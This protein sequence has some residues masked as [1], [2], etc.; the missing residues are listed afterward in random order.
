MVTLIMLSIAP[1]FRTIP[2]FTVRTHSQI[3]AVCALS[4]RFT[5]SS[6]NIKL[7]LA[8]LNTLNIDWSHV[9]RIQDLHSGTSKCWHVSSCLSVNACN[10]SA[11]TLLPLMM[12]RSA[13]GNDWWENRTLTSNKNIATLIGTRWRNPAY[14]WCYA[15]L[16]IFIQIQT[17]TFATNTYVL[18][19]HSTYMHLQI[20]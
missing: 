19:S 3:L 13:A 16:I 9:L 12:N 6:S 8:N 4:S 10:Q 2:C 15:P 11:H 5:S 1:I 20:M 18:W 14:P 7:K 17:A